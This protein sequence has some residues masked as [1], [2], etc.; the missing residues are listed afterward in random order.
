MP[1]AFLAHKEGGGEMPAENISHSDK[2]GQEYSMLDAIAE[3]MMHAIKSGNIEMLK[4]ALESYKEHIAEED[5]VED[6]K[7]FMP[8]EG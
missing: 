3:D 8:I 1:T 5:R 2:S 6:E 4:Y 7:Q